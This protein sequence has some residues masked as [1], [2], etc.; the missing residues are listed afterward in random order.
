MIRRSLALVFI[1]MFA[2]CGA[3][4]T[5]TSSNASTSSTAVASTGLQ[6]CAQQSG[7]TATSTDA[8]IQGEWTYQQKIGATTGTIHVSAAVP[9]DCKSFI[10]ATKPGGSGK[11]LG[12]LV[13]QYKNAGLAQMAFSGGVFGANPHT[14]G[15]LAGA[16]QGAATGFGA[17]SAY[18]FVASGSSPFGIAAWQSGTSVYVVVS[19]GLSE[20]DLKQAAGA[21][22]TG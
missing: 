14:I 20:T 6:S 7:D 17:S 15:Q 4:T 2:A 10:A 8:D 5:T 21:L 18:A 9:T 13:V 1:A 16:T 3:S 22:T 11:L 12:T 19:T